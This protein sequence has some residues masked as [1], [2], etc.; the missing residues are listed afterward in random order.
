MLSEPFAVV[1][2]RICRLQGQRFKTKTGATFTYSV[3]SGT[4]VWVERDARRINQS[5]VKSNFAQVY[6]MMQ[7]GPIDGPAEINKRAMKRGESQVRGPS[8][9]WAILD[10]NRAIP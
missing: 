9:V 1:W 2:T 7:D 10:D 4:T 6:S 8:Y 5:L 3:E